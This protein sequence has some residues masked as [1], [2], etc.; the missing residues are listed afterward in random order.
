[1]DYGVKP[2]MGGY[3][4]VCDNIMR[5]CYEHDDY[6]ACDNYPFLAEATSVWDN[7]GNNGASGDF[8][9]SS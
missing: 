1:M 8:G 7:I 9:I 4:L 2:C 3:S 6:M 5:Q